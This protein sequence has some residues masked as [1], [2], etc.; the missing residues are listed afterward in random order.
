M[1]TPTGERQ[2]LDLRLV[3]A[4][5]GCWVATIVAL[6]LGWF[7]G[8]ILAVGAVV[9]AIAL[10]VVW[11]WAVAH[12]RERWRVVAVAGLAAMLLAAG[13]GAAGAWRAYH[14]EAHPLRE[15]FG[16]TVSVVAVVT[17]DPKL[18][19]AGG[20]GGQRPW[21][22]HAGLREFGSG[23]GTTRVGGSLVIIAQGAEW[24]ALS[25]G[26]AIRFRG[27]V[28]EPTRSNL[29]VAA[30]HPVAAPEPVGVPPWWQRLATGVRADLSAAAAR[31]LS[32]AAAGLLPALVVGD[33]AALS[34]EVRDNFDITGLQHLA[35]VSGANFTILLTALLALTRLLTLGPRSSAIAAAGTVVVFVVLARPDPSV[36]R[37]AA[38]GSVTVLA[39]LTG[40]RKQAL[41]ALGAAVIGLLGVAP[42]LAVSAGFALSVLATA[43]L[44]LLAPSWA[45]WLRA[46]GWWRA[47]AEIVAVAAA[48]FVVTLPLMVALSGRVSLVAILANALVA[49]VVGVITVIG[50]MGAALAWLWGDAAVAVLWCARPPLWW[51]LSVAD[52]LAAVPGATMAVPEG[53]LGGL[54]AAAIMVLLI[55]ALRWS[56]TRRLLA[57]C[58]LG[59][60]TV[61]IPMRLWHPG[62]PPDGWAVAMCDVGQGDGL[63]LAVGPHAA[64]VIDTG[65]DPRAIRRCLDHLDITHIPLLVLTHPHADHIDGLAGAFR[66]RTITAIATAPGELDHSPPCPSTPRTGNKTAE[67]Q[68]ITHPRTSTAPAHSA[69]SPDVQPRS[70]APAHSKP[71]TDALPGVAGTAQP[72]PSTD[73]GLGFVAPAYS[74]PSTDAGLGV[75]VP[76]RSGPSTDA[77]LGVVV[78]VHSGPSTDA[79][80][81]VAT[82]ARSKPAIVA[83]SGDAVPAHSAPPADARSGDA[84]PAHSAPPAD[85]RSAS[86][87]PVHPKPPAEPATAAAPGGAVPVRSIPATDARHRGD[88]AAHS[89][90]AVGDAR[91]SAVP[92]GPGPA[93]NARP[94]NAAPAHPGPPIDARP[95][96][97]ALPASATVAWRGSATPMQ[98]ERPFVARSGDAAPADSA[99]A[100]ARRG[101][102]VPMYLA[103]AAVARQQGALPVRTA[104]AAVARLESAVPARSELPT[105]ARP[106]GPVPCCANGA[107]A[108]TCRE[109]QDVEPEHGVVQGKSSGASG[110][111]KVAELSKAAG[112][113]LLELSAGQ[114]LTF[115]AVELTVLAPAGNRASA[116]DADEANDR[117]V[118]LSARTSVGTVLLTGDIEAAA[119]ARVLRGGEVRADIL[120]VPHHGSRTTTPEFLGAVRPRLALIS[121]GADNTFG[122]PHPSITTALAALGATVARTDRDGDVVVFGTAAEPRVI[123]ARRRG[124]RGRKSPEPRG[125]DRA[126]P[127]CRRANVGSPGERTPCRGTSGSR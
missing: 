17:D 78:P 90:L 32:P 9:V 118:V 36:L 49:P 7:A 28:S 73:A 18:M 19:R 13:F 121:S 82:S 34:D 109:H 100:A 96:G 83:Q 25:P 41:P 70:T 38:M 74:G 62:W 105:D 15:S 102:V 113:S 12:E 11:L 119:Q 80:S 56:K 116:L 120:K 46:R 123:T 29:T 43:G 5:L 26:Q 14:V 55:A 30:L 16:R 8:V 54:V 93:T 104:P 122:H 1:A 88:A 44:I 39:L 51:L 110:M 63:A 127:A 65:P 72:V 75:V 95:G 76:V 52:R 50:A 27:K 67:P 58:A 45:D 86:A 68:N 4:A 92:V 81:G 61:L 77:G 111:A 103:P 117:S 79:R 33:T 24:S 53:A 114:V 99:L 69:P 10:W 57:V 91:G 108:P 85:A 22:V 40:R 35:V 97:A 20:F 47:P 124:P 64:V 94:D 89:K 66:G 107:A 42:Y 23:S 60:S 6:S 125:D 84:A 112:V 98:R 71:A 2:A 3:P 21:I 31:A 59:V 87:A 106:G 115:G 48:A 101:G 37:A 126:P